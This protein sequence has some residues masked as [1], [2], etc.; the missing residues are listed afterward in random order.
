MTRPPGLLSV[1]VVLLR[2]FHAACPCPAL[3]LEILN[4]VGNRPQ[5]SDK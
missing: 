3:S 4:G 5:S 1:A 2:A